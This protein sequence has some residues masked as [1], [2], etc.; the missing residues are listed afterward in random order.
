MHVHSSFR[1]HLT[2]IPKQLSS[3]NPP[4]IH[5]ALQR[6]STDT[7]L[8]YLSISWILSCPEPDD[9]QQMDAYMNWY[10]SASRQVS[11]LTL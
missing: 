8:L 10:T 6:A 9:S 3:I 5:L 7:S 1:A 4:T 2:G 11:Q